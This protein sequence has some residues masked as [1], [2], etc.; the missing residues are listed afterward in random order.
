MRGRGR[1]RN[2]RV[3]SINFGNG[4]FEKGREQTPKETNEGELSRKSDQGRRERM[5]RTTSTRKKGKKMEDTRK[6]SKR[7]EEE[8]WRKSGDADYAGNHLNRNH[9]QTLESWGLSLPPANPLILFFFNSL[10]IL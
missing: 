4:V 1:N 7:E 8:V 6:K 5:K 9:N 10:F 2:T 3:E